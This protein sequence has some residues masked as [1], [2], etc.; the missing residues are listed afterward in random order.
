ME[1][2][3]GKTIGS[4]PQKVKDTVKSVATM[5]LRQSRATN[6]WN[7]CII[8]EVITSIFICEVSFYLIN[9]FS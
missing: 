7:I 4:G 2:R 5:H 3:K 8:I 1:K 6:K 9:Q